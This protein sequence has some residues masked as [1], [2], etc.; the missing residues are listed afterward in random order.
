MAADSH[1]ISEDFNFMSSTL[2][3]ICMDNDQRCDSLD[4]QV[5][6]QFFYA[7]SLKGNLFIYSSEQVTSQRVM[8]H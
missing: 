6:M 3:N 4:S 5:F 8:S 2:Q 7:I 1:D